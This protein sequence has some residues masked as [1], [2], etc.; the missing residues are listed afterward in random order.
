MNNQENITDPD[1]EVKKNASMYFSWLPFCG[2]LV[3]IFTTIFLLFTKRE[4]SIP[5]LFY[6]LLPLIIFSL[7]ALFIHILLSKVLFLGYPYLKGKLKY[8]TILGFLL[9]ILLHIMIYSFNKKFEI[10]TI[11]LND[12]ANMETLVNDSSN[13]YIIYGAE[14]CIYCNKM[15][16]VYKKSFQN[17]KVK[18]V[19]YCDISDESY[20]DER[21][22]EL[23][24][25]KIPI[26]IRYEADKEKERLEGMKSIA[27]VKKFINNKEGY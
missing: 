14:N 4:W 23:N 20:I 5:L 26:L 3:S 11:N 25:Q 13:Y 24:V 8:I 18:E 21:L 27:D 1:Y 7:I 17:T 15:D 6:T 16:N 22:I 9:L 10:T 12:I 19:F 2:L